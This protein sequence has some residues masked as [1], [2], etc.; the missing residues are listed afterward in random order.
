MAKKRSEKQQEIEQLN[1]ELDRVTSVVL[2]TFQGLTV[3]QDTELRRAI[4]AAG[5][6]YRVLKNR[7][8]RRAAHGT[9]AEALL[10]Q[11]HGVNSIAYT[12]GDP[13]A[14]AKA[15]TR[16][17]KDNPAFTF[18]AGVVE[19]RVVSL[20]QLKELAALPAR[21]E[22]Y[23]K[24]LG[25]LQAPAQRLASLFAGPARALAVAVNQAVKEKKFSPAS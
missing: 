20:E 11:L 10:A 18:S 14:L 23:A 7:L 19:G 12:S 5:G 21:E 2:S 8:A 13:V 6:R 22:L 16:Y 24:L 1:Q 9:P 25:L 15:V 4:Q 17:A 3:Q